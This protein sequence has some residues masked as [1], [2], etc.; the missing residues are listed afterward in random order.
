MQFQRR[1]TE[2]W[3]FWWSDRMQMLRRVFLNVARGLVKSRRRGELP[4]VHL[5]EGILHSDRALKE[6]RPSLYPQYRSASYKILIF[7]LKGCP[8]IIDHLPVFHFLKKRVGKTSENML[9]FITFNITL[10]W[11]VRSESLPPRSRVAVA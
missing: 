6:K 9:F 1:S 3:M 2:F 5:K 10:W 11:I 4:R 8:S 7:G